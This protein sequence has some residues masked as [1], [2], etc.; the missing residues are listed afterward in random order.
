[1]TQDDQYRQVLENAERRRQEAQALD[2]GGRL[3]EAEVV[4]GEH[5]MGEE[6]E[7][8]L[9]GATTPENKNESNE[10]ERVRESM[11]SSRHS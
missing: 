11:K 6:I 3:R 2:A 7:E 1:M 5:F 10:L 8:E 9:F 4:D